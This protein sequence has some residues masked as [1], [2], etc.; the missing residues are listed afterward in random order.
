MPKT[1]V[2][3]E[4]PPRVGTIDEDDPFDLTTNVN[5]LLRRAHSRADKLFGE[6]MADIGLT[7]RQA[8]L[9]Y[10]VGLCPGGS[11]STL[12]RITGMDRGTLSEMSP[13]MVARGLLLRRQDENDGRAMALYLSEHGAELVR[14]VTLRSRTL[15]EKVLEPLPVEYRE[16]FIK[17]LLLLTGIEVETRTR[18]DFF[19][20]I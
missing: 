17:M 8:A 12:T 13:R 9:L 7:P 11:I 15:P 2:N 18:T 1:S 19:Q 5:Y 16:L 20:D 4:I 10:A 3:D 6:A 14:Q